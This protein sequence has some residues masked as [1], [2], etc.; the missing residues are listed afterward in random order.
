MMYKKIMIG[1]TILVL[2][3]LPLCTSVTYASQNADK[4][5][6][7]KLSLA[8]APEPAAALAYSLLPDFLDQKT[9]NAALLYYAAA[10]Q[11]PQD[12]PE[13][14]HKK[15]RDWRDVLVEQ[16]DRPSVEKVLALFS[17]SFHC[18][19]LAAQRRY[20]QWEMPLEDGFSM[21]ML[22][23]ST[24]RTLTYAMQLQIRLEMADGHTER[25]MALLRQGLYMARNIARGPSVI[26]GLVGVSITAVMLGE[27]EDLIQK[28]TAPNL[29]WA[30]TALPDPLVNLQASLAYEREVFFVTVPQL[31][32]LE[33]E[34]LTPGEADK[35]IDKVMSE[36]QKLGMT[37]DVPLQGL[38][39]MAWVMMH[40]TDA[41]TFLKR[42]GVAQKRIEAMPAAQ[43]VLL[44]QKQQYLHLVD[45]QF[46]WF[47]VPYSQAHSHLKQAADATDSHLRSQ[48]IKSNFFAMLTPAL[49]RIAFLQARLE[50]QVALLRVVEAIRLFAANHSGKI[51]GALSE[52][53][54]VPVP[55]DPVT[56]KAFLYQRTDAQNARLEAPVSPVEDKR[57]PVYELAVTH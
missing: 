22:P 29:Y 23:L 49:S 34:I 2:G 39:P 17:S 53:T 24:F 40:Y 26:H 27:V 12:G 21:Q 50:R 46:K 8:A 19:E 35:I 15:I 52:I 43:A 36:M 45:D 14:N 9:D 33:K 57:R 30:L 3:V 7:T 38:L 48:G 28:P 18:I 37:N 13:A 1:S 55:M 5:K 25:A 6:L 4:V 10:A 11:C 54:V 56:G 42:H 20:C 31:R 32:D 51:P 47:A 44:Y 16:W 41:K